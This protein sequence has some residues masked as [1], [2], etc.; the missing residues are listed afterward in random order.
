M[1]LL[2]SWSGPTPLASQ[3]YPKS[4]FDSFLNSHVESFVARDF[5]FFCC[6]V[7]RT[8]FQENS[9]MLLDAN[10]IFTVVL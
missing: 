8:D 5:F 10:G 2:K 3:M 7:L 4:H 9:G 6:L 1:Q